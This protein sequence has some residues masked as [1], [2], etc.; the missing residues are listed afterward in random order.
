MTS[1]LPL[2]TSLLLCLSFHPLSI[3]LFSL[4]LPPP[5]THTSPLRFLFHLSF[6][7]SFRPFH[8]SSI[9]LSF[10]QFFCLSVLFLSTYFTLPQSTPLT[11]HTQTQVSFALLPCSVP[12]SLPPDPPFLGTCASTPIHPRNTFKKSPKESIL[13]TASLYKGPL[14]FHTSTL[15]R[16]EG[17]PFWRCKLFC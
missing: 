8:A 7:P 15:R 3:T 4:L 13:A 6:P 2:P 9:A 17:Q 14:K 11:L 1:L 12:P 5:S 10:F 16:L